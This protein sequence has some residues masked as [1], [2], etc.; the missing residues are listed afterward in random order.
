MSSV[1]SVVG[2]QAFHYSD[3]KVMNMMLWGYSF[4]EHIDSWS[5]LK[6]FIHWPVGHTESLPKLCNQEPYQF[7]HF[8][9]RKLPLART[10]TNKQSYRSQ[11]VKLVYLGTFPELWTCWIRSLFSFWQVLGSICWAH[12]SEWCL[13]ISNMASVAL[14]SRGLIQC[15]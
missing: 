6:V 2:G 15:S 5:Q 9:A 8:F 11:K 12:K 4:R 14:G 10:V 7:W 1:S 3:V 13:G